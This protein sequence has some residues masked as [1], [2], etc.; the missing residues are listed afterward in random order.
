MAPHPQRPRRSR[1]GGHLGM[2]PHPQG[3]F[4]RMSP[5]C[6]PKREQQ[7]DVPE[8]VPKTEEYH[9]CLFQWG[10]HVPVDPWL[11]PI[12]NFLSLASTHE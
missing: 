8:T 6:S 11:T 3:M 12:E 9:K 2:A 5:Y 10:E 7:V 1:K 4:P